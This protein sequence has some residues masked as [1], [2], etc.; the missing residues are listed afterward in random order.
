MKKTT[1]LLA[2]TCITFFFGCNPLKPGPLATTS[3]FVKADSIPG[4]IAEAM[5]D[6]FL[7]TVLVDHSQDSLI[8]QVTLHNSDLNKIFKMK[9]ITRIRLL[10]AAYLNTDPIVGRRNRLTMLVQLKQGYNS[11]YY[12][13]DVRD[14]GEARLCPP[15]NMCSDLL[16]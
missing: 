11:N 16:N 1:I 15:P 5:I 14:L 7:D 10:A 13:Y 9:N 12:Y 2:I 6:H 8:K 4:T 3:S